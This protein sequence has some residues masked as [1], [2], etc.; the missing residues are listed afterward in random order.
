MNVKNPLDDLLS[1]YHFDL[2]P[3]YIAQRPA[4]I[5]RLLVYN[6]QTDEVIHDVFPNIGKYLPKDSLLVFNRSRVFPSRLIGKKSSGGKAEIFILS[7]VATNSLYPVLIRTTSKK[8]IGDC[9]TFSEGMKATLKEAFSD[10]TFGVIFNQDNL[11]DYLEKHARI[12][13]PPY[14]RKG[15]S[16]DLD[17]KDYQTSYARE[18]G[19]VAA[20]TAGLHFGHE[21]LAKLKEQQIETAF[22]TLHVGLGTFKPVTAERLSEHRM[23]S[24]NYFIDEANAQILKEARL[25]HKKIFAVG[26]TSLRVL[27][28]SYG[29]NISPGKVYSTNI[30]LHPGKEI[31]S[32]DGL[33]TNF[34]LPESSLL[35][36]VSTLTGREKALELYN[37]AIKE[38]YRFFS[39]GDGML[40]L[41]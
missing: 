20:P 19:S 35:M 10:G 37:I 1:S 8:K 6:L 4:E 9:Y 5:S 33:I 36:L 14:I 40:I 32:V 41:R 17:R 3:E 13:I 11:A 18:T 31:L 22:V 38:K 15:E 26:T 23:H 28:S 25:K 12:P 24:E 30:F 29:Q 27:E 7:A 39:Y 2:P 16:D 21:L 34:H